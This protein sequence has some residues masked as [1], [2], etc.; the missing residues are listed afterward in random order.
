MKGFFTSNEGIAITAGSLVALCAAKVYFSGGVC[1]VDRD[2][3]NQIILVTGGSAGL[4]KE[5]IKSLASKG[6]T[7]I[8]GARDKVKSENVVKEIL[9]KNPDCNI[10]F[11]PLD[12]ADK[13]SIEAFS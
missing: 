4:G 13:S 9:E 3:T 7:I 10:H 12:L 2:L 6:C 11:F 5:T 1:R 8:F